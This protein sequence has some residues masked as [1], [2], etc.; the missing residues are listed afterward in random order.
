MKVFIDV[1]GSQPAYRGEQ[2]GAMLLKFLSLYAEGRYWL[3][4]HKVEKT[5]PFGPSMGP[6]EIDSGGGGTDPSCLKDELA[7]GNELKLMLT[8]G[9]FAPIGFPTR[10]LITVDPCVG[11][12]DPKFLALQLSLLDDMLQ[13]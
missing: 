6:I 5:R 2:K 11:G 9:M 7:S 10:N 8:D 4:D 13:K 1:S 12:Y 3:F